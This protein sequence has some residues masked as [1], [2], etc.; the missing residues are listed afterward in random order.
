[1][2]IPRRTN[3]VTFCE[4]RQ[5]QIPRP[6]ARLSPD[7]LFAFAPVGRGQHTVASDNEEFIVVGNLVHNHVGI[8]RDD[9]LLWREFCALLELE[10]SN[11]AGERQITIDPSKINKPTS[12]HDPSLLAYKQVRRRYGLGKEKQRKKK[13]KERRKKKEERRKKREERRRKKKEERGKK[14]ER[15]KEE[16]RRKKKEERRK[17]KERK[18]K[19]KKKE[20]R[21]K[22]KEKKGKNKPSFC[23][24]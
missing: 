14:K 3:S 17:K 19:R 5:S 13:K 24:L 22:K 8:C 16:E 11:G 7:S 4:D 1:M 12:S 2:A 6:T 20:G 21:K 10:I 23:G 18:K 15:R 9:L